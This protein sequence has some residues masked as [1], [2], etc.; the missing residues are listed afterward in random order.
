MPH[1]LTATEPGAAEPATAHWQLATGNWQLVRQL[2]L[3]V[4]VSLA[5]CF[6]KNAKG[7]N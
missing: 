7:R 6:R 4:S 1:L 2:T 5:K 3:E